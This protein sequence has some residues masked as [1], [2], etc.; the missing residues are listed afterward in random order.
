MSAPT[1]EPQ[2]LLSGLLYSKS[3]SNDSRFYNERF[4]AIIETLD[5]T[6]TKEG[7]NKLAIEGT[8]ILLEELP[9]IFLCHKQGI[10]I[11]KS[12]VTGV[13]RFVNDIQHIDKRVKID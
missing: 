3:D 7:R 6:F 1:L 9:V 4:D 8:E 10:V 12:N 2:H 5:E 13:H 11:T